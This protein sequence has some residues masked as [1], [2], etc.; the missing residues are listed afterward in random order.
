VN[1]T[2]I[3]LCSFYV[4]V[5]IGTW[6]VFMEWV[7]NSGVLSYDDPPSNWESDCDLL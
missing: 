3:K 1:H 5:R 6:G 7:Q 2:H 4:S